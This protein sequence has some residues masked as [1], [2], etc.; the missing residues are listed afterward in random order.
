MFYMFLIFR[1]KFIANIYYMAT[2]L[3]TSRFQ[4]IT[5]FKMLQELVMFQF[6]HCLLCL[7]STLNALSYVRHLG[8]LK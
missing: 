1:I 2:L 7:I 8:I 4:N 6:M 5:Q 3:A